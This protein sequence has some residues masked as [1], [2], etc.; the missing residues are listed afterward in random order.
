VHQIFRI[1]GDDGTADMELI[2][3][4]R[5]PSQPSATRQPF[6]LAFR[7]PAAPGWPQRTCR[8]SAAGLGELDVFL[9]PIGPD[10]KGMQYEAIFS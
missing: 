4:R 6:A 5:L 8:V 10:A 9:V 7:G 2:S 1:E 3:I